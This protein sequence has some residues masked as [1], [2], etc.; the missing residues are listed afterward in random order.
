MNEIEELLMYAGIAIGSV[1]LLTAIA[2]G[3]FDQIYENSRI[4]VI[5]DLSNLRRVKKRNALTLLNLIE[6]LEDLNEVETELNQVIRATNS[7]SYK[8][9][10]KTD[11][12][13]RYKKLEREKSH[14]E[15]RLKVPAK[16]RI[17]LTRFRANPNYQTLFEDPAIITYLL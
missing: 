10:K 4:K 2:V 13:K 3:T 14:L 7:L 6:Q 11:L 9:C 17:S 12:P 15:S 8:D 16:L 1:N 5:K